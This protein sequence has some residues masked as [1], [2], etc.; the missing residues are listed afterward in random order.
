MPSDFTYFVVLLEAVA[1]AATSETLIRAHVAFLKKLD[2]E[3]KL[4]MCGPFTGYPGG[5]IILEAS[6]M[7]EAQAI[8]AQDPFVQRGV[9]TA[10]VRAWELSCEENNHM[11]M[12]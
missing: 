9:R 11:G 1:G 10:E 5:M 8:A 4:V 6:G 12:G 2:G 7:E 3:G